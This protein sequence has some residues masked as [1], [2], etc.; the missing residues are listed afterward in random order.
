MT[1]RTVSLSVLRQ[2]DEVLIA[3]RHFDYLPQ[4]RWMAYATAQI[5]AGHQV[6]LYLV[7]RGVGANTALDFGAPPPLALARAS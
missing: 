4:D 3:R 5:E 1:R 7:P 6:A 2:S